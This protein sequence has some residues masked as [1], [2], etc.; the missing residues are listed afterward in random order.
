[1]KDTTKN[2]LIAVLSLYVLMDIGAAY[3]MTKSHPRAL[4]AFLSAFDNPL[5]VAY[6]AFC[7]YGCPLHIW[8]YIWLTM[9][10]RQLDNT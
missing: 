1:M 7:V 4:S 3:L 6:I 9:I 2:A 5:Y 10:D 8:L